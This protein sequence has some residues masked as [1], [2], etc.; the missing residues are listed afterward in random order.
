M[1]DMI[2]FLACPKCRGNLSRVEDSLACA[3]CDRRYPVV[4]DVPQFDLPT[5]I[6][7]GAAEGARDVRRDYWD[8]GWKAR[9]QG[10]HAFQAT[11]Q[12]RSDW[13]AYLE[14]EMQVLGESRH[15]MVVE[16]NRAAVHDK[17]VLDIGCGSGTSGALF[18]YLGA[19]Y[20]GVDHSR[21]AAAQA[22]RNLRAAGGDGFTAQG[23][24]EALPI[25]DGSIDVVYSNGVLHHTPN[26][27]TAMD[28]A[29]RVLKPGG[30]AIIALYATYSTQF[31]VTRL[32][33]VLRGHISRGAQ[34][35]WM[36]E[37]SEGAW[38]TGDRL[39]PWTQTFSKAQLRK[40]IGKYSLRKLVIRK[41]G[42]P[43]GDFP[44]YGF[45][46]M[47]FAPIRALDRLLE[48]TLGSMLV[49][50]FDKDVGATSPTA[51]R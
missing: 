10:D 34:I 43:I 12:T 14:R 49:M 15:V 17:V 20:I 35:R 41:N 25:R 8:N 2:S 11:L 46:L 7:G 42:R 38:R 37:A 48:P 28:E 29:Y 30:K 16:A 26:F 4:D 36:G 23:N 22:L 32:A 9:I 21:H 33:G 47:R 44:D 31:G 19:H 24:A 1:I 6:V 50:S 45:R 27:L 13:S 18:G 3:N 51:A 5:S 39:N 40:I